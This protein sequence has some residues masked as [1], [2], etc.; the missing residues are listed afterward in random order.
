[1]MGKRGESV[2]VKR[3]AVSVETMAPIRR[4]VVDYE[5]FTGDTHAVE[6]VVLQAQVSG[7]LTKCDFT[8]GEVVKKNDVLFEIEPELYQAELDTAV[9]NLESAKG[10]LTVLK[11][12]EPQLRIELDRNTKLVRS[13]AV[14]QSDYDEAK[15]ALDECLAKITKAEADILKASAEVQQA[16]INLKYTKI[17]SPIDGRISRKLVTEGNLVRD[18]ET[19]LARIVSHDPIYVFFYVDEATYLKLTE[20]AKNQAETLSE[21]E[22]LRIEFR[23]TNEESWTDTEGNP[24]HA[25][26]VLYAD[27]QMDGTSGTVL[28][29]ATCPNTP[30]GSGQFSGIIPGMMVHIRIPVTNRYSALLVP[31]EAFGTEQGTRYLYVKNA[32]G[33]AEMRRPELG[34][35]QGDNMR[36]VR[37]EI[38]ETDEV[39]VSGLLRLRPGAEVDV[40]ETTL[41]K[42]R[43]GF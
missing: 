41:E 32:E 26:T 3:A 42:L 17:L 11:A 27:P 12:R 13:N 8:E 14:S 37:S 29:R 1:M 33:K 10:E 6:N 21:P 19:V 24:L 38:E 28:L 34:P 22:E 39:I 30:V 4:E 40:K 31:E 2:Q 5:E 15:A 23:L 20:N 35:L 43:K 16:A 7:I 36:V 25:G 9:G 18:H